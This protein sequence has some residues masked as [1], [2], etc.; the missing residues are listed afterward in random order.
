MKALGIGAAVVSILAAGAPARAD[1]SMGA[2]PPDA[3]ALVDVPKAA[4]DAPK[5]D[6][7]TNETTATVSAGGQAAS[8][9]SRLIAAT[10]NGKFDWRRDANGFGAALVANYGESQT[11]GQSHLITTTEN[12]QGRLRYDRYLLDQLSLF[13]IGTGRH[14]R[15]QGLDFRLNVDPGAKYL[16]VNTDPT[17]FWGELGYDFQYDVRRDDARIQLDA[18]GAPDLTLPLL[19]KTANDHS[20]RA[21]L[22]LKHAFNSQ[23]TLTTG[24]EYLQSLVETT[25][26]RL[27]YDALFAANVGGGFSLGLGFTA[28]WD[29][30]PLPGK[31]DLDTTS[32]V[33]LIY[34]FSDAVPKPEAPAC[35]PAPAPPPP[36]AVN[37]PPAQVPEVNPPA[38][39]PPDANPPPAPAPDQ[40]LPPPAAPGDPVPPA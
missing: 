3:T 15:F 32:T 18:T 19:A 36:P 38:T 10:A 12:I 9:N 24:I 4:E 28:R 11:T 25:R 31:K 1:D 6:S 17:T 5:I 7:P 2:P 27:N 34:A 26:A 29:H 20:A 30:S 23:V 40:P 14:D 33:S 21:F 22:G 16:F 35:E 13:V 8:G 37:T 39:I